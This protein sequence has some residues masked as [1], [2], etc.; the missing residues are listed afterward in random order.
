[1]NFFSSFVIS[2]FCFLM[3]IYQVTSEIKVQ[4]FYGSNGMQQKVD[5]FNS[6]QPFNRNDWTEMKNNF[7][8]NFILFKS[9]YQSVGLIQ[10]WVQLMLKWVPNQYLEINR[11]FS[12]WAVN[13]EFPNFLISTPIS[14]SKSI[15]LPILP[16]MLPFCSLLS[17]VPFHPRQKRNF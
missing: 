5:F 9:N 1:M 7:T 17:S 8:G 16:Q 11:T 6:T 4:T 15:F 3:S 2:V 14:L 13:V 12:E 10:E